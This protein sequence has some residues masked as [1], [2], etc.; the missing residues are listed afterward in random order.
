MGRII[1]AYCDESRQTSERF[2]VLG[3]MAIPESLAASFN[4]SIAQCRHENR[5]TAEFKWRK[6]SRAKINEYKKFIDCFF[7][8]NN[9]SHA[10]F[11][12]LIIDTNQI[13]YSR[14]GC[15]KEVGFYKFYYQLLLHCFGKN[16][17]KAY[18]D[19]RILTYLDYRN[20]SYPL[21][22]LKEIL[23]FGMNKKF[24]VATDPFRSV[25][26]RDSHHCQP[27]QIVDV[28]IGAIGY[29]KNG[30]D[31]IAGASEAKKELAMYIQSKSGL[32]DFTQSTPLSVQRFTVWNFRLQK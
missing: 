29:K 13:N 2:M 12:A 27:I 22:K 20:S 6:V 19:N 9:T 25:E 4:A 14:F 23:N 5:M 16:Y 3:G 11:H 28:L 24:Q 18:P 10:H 32:H 30:F 8:L 26:P 15:D 1:H 7:A 21:S 17:C 31:L